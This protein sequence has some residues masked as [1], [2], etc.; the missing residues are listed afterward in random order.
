MMNNELEPQQK[1]V[2]VDFENALMNNGLELEEVFSSWRKKGTKEF[3]RGLVNLL[4]G[5]YEV[6]YSLDSLP[7]SSNAISILTESYEDYEVI[8]LSHYRH[9][10]YAKRAADELSEA[11]LF[12]SSYL[13]YETQGEKERIV[14]SADY[15]CGSLVDLQI[16]RK[17]SSV[18]FILPLNFG[19]ILSFFTKKH[20]TN[21]SLMFSGLFHV[22]WKHLAIVWP[23]ITFW[24]AMFEIHS[25]RLHT[26]MGSFL[27]SIIWISFMH[28]A[29][30]FREIDR[31]RSF[32]QQMR[33]PLCAEDF[34]Y[35]DNSLRVAITFSCL[36]FLIGI[37]L[38][39]KYPIGSLVGCV[40]GLTYFVFLLSPFRTIAMIGVAIL[41][42]LTVQPQFALVFF[43]NL[44][45]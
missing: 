32:T 16:V 36:Y 5:K 1:V 45:S 2:L 25:L 9:E 28:L 44:I 27:S 26:V 13:L 18:S 7:Y 4:H 38:F 21:R 33:R 10:I 3:L 35:G 37:F 39:I 14:D 8:L 23:I 17:A 12:T 34:I 19:F 20:I 40:M 29:R 31:E 6:N 30:T 15:I 41:S 11:G 42:Q 24:P 43:K 22:F